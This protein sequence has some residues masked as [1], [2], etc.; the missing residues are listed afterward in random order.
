MVSEKE[1][2]EL[3]S[4]EFLIIAAA[5]KYLARLRVKM[6]HIGLNLVMDIPAF[7][8]LPVPIQPLQQEVQSESIEANS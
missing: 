3:H 6:M 4:L 8:Q 1:H 7:Q 5:Q 2:P